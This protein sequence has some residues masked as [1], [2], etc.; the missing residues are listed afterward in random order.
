MNACVVIPRRKK[1]KMLRLLSDSI[2]RVQYDT[3]TAALFTS[4]KPVLGLK[5]YRQRFDYNTVRRHTPALLLSTEAT[6]SSRYHC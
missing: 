6:D 5:K 4:T 2:L 3:K 1:E